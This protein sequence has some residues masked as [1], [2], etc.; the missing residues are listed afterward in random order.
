MK[1]SI[2]DTQYIITDQNNH[3]QMLKSLGKMWMD[4]MGVGSASVDSPKQRQRGKC[5]SELLIF[6]SCHYSLNNIV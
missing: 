6:F 3:Q 5:A 2:L 1:I 4:T